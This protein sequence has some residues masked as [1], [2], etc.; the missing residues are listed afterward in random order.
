MCHELKKGYLVGIGKRWSK[1]A[2]VHMQAQ[3]PVVVGGAIA[4]CYAG[5]KG[6]GKRAIKGRLDE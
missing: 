3:M 6:K 2:V 1:A 4:N 5:K